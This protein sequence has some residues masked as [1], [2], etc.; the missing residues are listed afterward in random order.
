MKSPKVST[1]IL[2]GAPICLVPLL[3]V[4]ARE[5]RHL[6]NPDAVSF[7]RFASYYANGQ[8]D[9]AI[10]GW[11][12]PMLSWLIAPL[13]QVIPDPLIAVRTVMAVSALI[14]LWGSV[15]LLQNLQL[16]R[17]WVILGAWVTAVATVY[18]S[19]MVITPDLLFDGILFLAISE[20]VSDRWMAGWRSPVL[21]GGLAGLSY[22]A[23]PVGVPTF[24]GSV[25]VLG[26]FRILGRPGDRATVFRSVGLTVAG[27]LLVALPW[28]VTLSVKYGRPTYYTGSRIAHA[29]VGPPEVNHGYPAMLRKP[30]PG[31][32][33]W[34][35]DPTEMIPEF[36][37]WSPLESRTYAKHQIKVILSNA[38]GMLTTLGQFDTLRLGLAAAI[39]GLLVHAPWGEHLR[40]ERW[41]WSGALVACACAIYLP[42]YAED[43]RYYLVAYPF[44]FAA[45]VG[46]VVSLTVDVPGRLNVPRWIGFGILAVSFLSAQRSHLMEALHG[47]DDPFST[48]AGDLAK[49]LSARGIRGTVAGAGDFSDF[50]GGEYVGLYVAFLLDQP[51]YGSDP[52]P[53][54]EAFKASGAELIVLERKEPVVAE[55]ANDQE[56]V[57]LDTVLFATPREAVQYPLKV[58]QQSG[59]LR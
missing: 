17:P 7:V 40:R 32:L 2:L 18:W 10:C 49:R 33:F 58:F 39:L 16:P 9:L 59:A 56:F 43:Y 38:E 6:L 34:G 14:F 29:L 45:A 51:F 13:L 50:W 5:N 27:F 55:M 41:R 44:L 35:E 24:L 57:D 12:G 3:I 26:W 42:V 37:T 47:L 1:V 28:I 53:T 36:R 54:P 48:A 19:V 11:F 25:L 31:R 8:L 4:A 30:Q 22:L 52:H 15:R 23:K 46:V 21:A 20:M